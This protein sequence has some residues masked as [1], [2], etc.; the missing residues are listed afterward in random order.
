MNKNNN[1]EERSQVSGIEIVRAAN[2]DSEDVGEVPQE[3][4]LQL[5]ADHLLALNL[6]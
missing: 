6:E 3:Q 5:V 2:D 4:H 1:D